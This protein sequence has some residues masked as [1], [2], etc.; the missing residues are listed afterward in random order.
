[1]QL[2]AVIKPADCKCA[3][4]AWC[5]LHCYLERKQRVLTHLENNVFFSFF[6]LALCDLAVTF[7]TSTTRSLSQI[8]CHTFHTVCYTHTVYTPHCAWCYKSQST[9]DRPCVKRNSPSLTQASGG[10]QSDS[11]WQRCVE[12]VH[13]WAGTRPLCPVNGDSRRSCLYRVSMELC[14]R[15]R[16]QCLIWLLSFFST[17]G[18][19]YLACGLVH[20]CNKACFLQID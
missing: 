11:I 9:V 15:W 8:Q 4:Y 10:A 19:K 6:F 3:Y 16:R 17:E 7:E 20:A 18:E 13:V 2:A 12:G 5:S 14:C 1:M